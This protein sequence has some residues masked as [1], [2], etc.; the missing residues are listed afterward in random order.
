MLL[1]TKEDVSES[2]MWCKLWQ[3]FGGE[4]A[5]SMKEMGVMGRNL[6][7]RACNNTSSI[8]LRA[9]ASNLCPNASTWSNRIDRSNR[10]HS[11]NWSGSIHRIELIDQSITY[12]THI[13]IWYQEASSQLLLRQSNFTRLCVEEC[14]QTPTCGLV[15]LGIEVSSILAAVDRHVNARSLN[16]CADLT[17]QA[18]TMQAERVS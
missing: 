7:C 13:T 5:K 6:Q 3:V 8:C 9:E 1:S 15:K 18:H 11:S 2:S 4:R 17:W 12:K 14:Q 10:I 16:I